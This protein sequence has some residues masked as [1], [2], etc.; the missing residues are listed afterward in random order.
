MESIGEFFK[1]LL[2]LIWQGIVII[3]SLLKTGFLKFWKVIVVIIT[4]IISVI[5]LRIFKKKGGQLE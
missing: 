1:T 2:S 4:F 3:F 5:T